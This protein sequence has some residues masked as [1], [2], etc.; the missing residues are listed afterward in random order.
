ML[1][2]LYDLCVKLQRATV[3][4]SE[5]PI[6]RVT[7]LP[8]SVH[9]SEGW[10]VGLVIAVTLVISRVVRQSPRASVSCNSL[11][12]LKT[13]FAHRLAKLF[14]KQ[15]RKSLS[16]TRKGVC[17]TVVTAGHCTH[18]ELTSGLASASCYSCCVHS[19]GLC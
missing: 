7:T 19:R 15:V 10:Q 13:V 1:L 14:L 6:C 9:V 16:R 12:C 8:G 2:M 18:A 3:I 5:L 11:R 17:A 4:R